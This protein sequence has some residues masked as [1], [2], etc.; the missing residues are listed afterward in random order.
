MDENYSNYIEKCFSSIPS[1]TKIARFNVD[2][3]Y[4][5]FPFF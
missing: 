1:P 3:Q 4:T 5:M 2:E